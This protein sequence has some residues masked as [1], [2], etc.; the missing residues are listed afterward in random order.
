MNRLLVCFISLACF[1]TVS[2]CNKVSKLFT[3][4]ETVGRD[5]TPALAHA[6]PQI[7]KGL[8][9]L[10]GSVLS[11]NLQKVAIESPTGF[12]SQVIVSA[13]HYLKPNEKYSVSSATKAILNGIQENSQDAII[14]PSGE[15]AFVSGRT[16]HVLAFVTAAG[17]CTVVNCPKVMAEN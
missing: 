4:A 1:A 13:A 17:G 11:Q 3:A 6:T 7:W 8:S 14:D 12:E 5:A 16:I 15:T 10:S 2:G 9:H